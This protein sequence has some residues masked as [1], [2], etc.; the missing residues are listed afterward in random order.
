M[1]DTPKEAVPGGTPGGGQIDDNEIQVSSNVEPGLVAAADAHG[2]TIDETLMTFSTVFKKMTSAL[3][4]Y[5][6]QIAQGELDSS[7]VG[8][9]MRQVWPLLSISM[10]QESKLNDQIEQ[11]VGR[12]GKY[13]FDLE[14]ARSE[15]GGRLACL[16]DAGRRSGVSEQSE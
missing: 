1:S 7:E 9:G 13:A 5:A 11:R 15:I 4:G 2:K 12:A 10:N 6:D 8:S 3:L 14:E 16:R